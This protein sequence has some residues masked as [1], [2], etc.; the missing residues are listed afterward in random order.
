MQLSLEKLF[1]YP[2][3]QNLKIEQYRREG[4][5]EAS[6]VAVQPKYIFPKKN[7]WSSKG[8]AS[9]IHEGLSL[10]DMQKCLLEMKEKI[11]LML[12]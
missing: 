6:G 9:A 10:L 11:N 4:W 7:V 3:F 12:G 2:L 8:D 1:P 5:R